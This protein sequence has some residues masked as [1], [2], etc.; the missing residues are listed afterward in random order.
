MTIVDTVYFQKYNQAMTETK[1]E[2]LLVKA[3]T[4]H[5]IE[6]F[7]EAK[8]AEIKAQCT[9]AYDDFIVKRGQEKFGD[10]V[11]YQIRDYMSGHDNQTV[12]ADIEQKVTQL[13]DEFM[14]EMSKN[15]S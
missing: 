1:F 5:E 2:D 3:V 4:G 14:E 9:A 11:A 12:I 7:D 15:N 13:T 8:Q 10:K 6:D